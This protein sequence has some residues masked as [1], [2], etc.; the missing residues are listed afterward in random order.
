MTPESS[1]HACYS[2]YGRSHRTNG[3]VNLDP[4]PCFSTQPY[5][6]NAVLF[7]AKEMED[8]DFHVI[9]IR[10]NGWTRQPQE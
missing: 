3:V 6:H 4:W 8:Q 1:L 10:I 2:R 5:E 7:V 9:L